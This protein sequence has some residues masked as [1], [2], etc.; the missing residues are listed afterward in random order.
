MSDNLKDLSEIQSFINSQLV[1]QPS[2]QEQ[3]LNQSL[4]D[5]NQNISYSF[6]YIINNLSNKSSDSTWPSHIYSIL[7][8]N[9]N[10]LYLGF[11][12]LFLYILLVVFT[13]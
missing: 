3:F 2:F 10:F 6:L 4:S 8:H 13:N 12:F 1:K 11:L 5:F 9:N 7:S